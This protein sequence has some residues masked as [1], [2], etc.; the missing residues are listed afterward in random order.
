MKVPAS[1]RAK[2]VAAALLMLVG[3]EGLSLKSYQ[4]SGGVWTICYGY[5]QGVKP[6][7]VAT[8]EQ[9]WSMLE[10]EAKAI[11]A[12]IAP[13]MPADIRPNQLAALIDFCYNVGVPTCKG[14]TL[15]RYASQ[16]RYDLV[17]GQFPRWKY[18]KGKDCT[19]AASNCS[20]I[21]KRRAAEAALWNQKE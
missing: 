3:A 15:Y 6:G 9:C 14:S 7:Q 16:G 12:K 4:D 19:L 5:A 2:A 21:P 10:S 1:T 17:A 8:K 13:D 18:V 20:G 11:E